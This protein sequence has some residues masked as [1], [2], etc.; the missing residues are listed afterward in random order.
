[1]SGLITRIIINALALIVVVFV[2]GER[3]Q[4]PAMQ[5]VDGLTQYLVLGLIFGVVNA[6]V[7]PIL[8]FL[9]CPLVILT[10]GLFTFIINAAMLMLTSAIAQ[11]LGVNFRV[12]G[13]LSAILGSIII[14]IV[15]IALTT[16]VRDE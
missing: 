3:V 2:L 4:G 1:M 5:S 10:L 11:Q 16:L 14:S 7:R 15:S 12:D 6:L 13:W 9:S 8:T